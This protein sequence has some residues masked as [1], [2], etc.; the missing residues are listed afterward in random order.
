MTNVLSNAF[1]RRNYQFE[2]LSD[3]KKDQPSMENHFFTLVKLLCQC[4]CKIRF[5]HIAKTTTEKI[6]DDSVRNKLSKTSENVTQ[7][8]K[9]SGELQKHYSYNLCT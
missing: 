1:E 9:Q 3:H 2:S 6:M 7:K 5:H 4:Y 8:L